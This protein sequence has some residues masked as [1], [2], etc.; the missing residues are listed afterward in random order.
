MFLVLLLTLLMLLLTLLTLLLT[1][2][3]LLLMLL[4][5]LTLLLMLLTL[6][7]TL[8]T[9]LTLL[10]T[11]LL[12]LLTLLLMPLVLLL[13]FL[14]LH[15]SSFCSSSCSS[16]F[17]PLLALLPRTADSLPSCTVESCHLLLTSSWST[18][19]PP[20]VFR[21]EPMWLTEELPWCMHCLLSTYKLTVHP[22]SPHIL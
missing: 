10:L 4:M 16:I 20:K 22:H 18:L 11:L 6:L 2:L 13:T 7:L 9:L 5:L 17:T 14:V 21:N 1:L 19:M 15:H 8:L 12:M 3:T